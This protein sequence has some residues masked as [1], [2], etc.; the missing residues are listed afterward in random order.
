[1]N[2]ERRQISQRPTGKEIVLHIDDLHQCVDEAHVRIGEMAD[3][4]T[5]HTATLAAHGKDLGDLK[6]NQEILLGHFGYESRVGT[7]G[8]VTY[9][10]PERSWWKRVEVPVGI[11]S[12][13][14]AILGVRAVLIAIAKA[15]FLALRT[16]P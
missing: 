5:G 4:V 6:R 11:A 1:M 2:R 14:L 16:A 12:F 7:D 15:V 13:I 9:H 8:T 3:A 10:L